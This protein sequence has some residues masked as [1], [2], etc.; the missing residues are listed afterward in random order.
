MP[1]LLQTLTPALVAIFWGLVPVY[2][3]TSNQIGNFLVP[4]F[5]NYAL[6]GGLGMIILGLFV[7]LTSRQQSD[8]GHDHQDCDHDHDHAEQSPLTIL[9]LMALPVGA[10]LTTDTSAGFS[11]DVLERKGLYDSKIDPSAYQIPPFTREMLEN[12]TPRSQNGHFQLPVGQL[13]F[14]SGDSSMREV[15]TDLPVET[16]GQVVPERDNNE[17][18]DRLRIYRTV[19]TCCAA[20]ALVLGFPIIF[21]EI[22]PVIE[23][24]A[25][26]RIEGTMAYEDSS[27]G[28]LPVFKVESFEIIPPPENGAWTGMW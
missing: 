6:F 28:P 15:F 18:G 2:L 1:K 20:D 16:E 23:E 10:A 11:L 8:C 3:F 12:S 21:N 27:D 22:A 14:S 24:R 19:M 4:K 9:L 5:H 7:A 17:N 25:W 26:V 13:F